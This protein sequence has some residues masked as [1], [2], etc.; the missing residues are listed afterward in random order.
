MKASY[1]WLR[2]LL[3]GLDLSPRDAG[4]RLTRA[5]L[6]LE[7]LIEYG[8]ASPHCVVATV[9]KKEP[10]PKR[11]RLTLVTVDRGDGEQTIVCGAPNVPE[12]G[13]KV[14]LAPVGVELPE[15]GFT[16]V[17]RDIA[18]VTSEGM[19]CSEGELGL[20][21][22]GKGDGILVLDKSVKA[23]AGTPF[24]KAVAGTHDWVLDIG[25]TP[26]RPDAL[27]HVGI[28]RELAALLE[29]DFEAP[30]ADAPARVAQGKTIDELA[31]VVID[32][33]ERCPHYG[34]AAVLDVK[35]GPSP[36]WLRYRLESLGIR[37]ISN[38]VDVTNLVLLEFAQPMH[39]FN[40]D[41]LPGGK[42]RV[43]R[44]KPGELLTTIDHVERKLV[45]DDLLIT[46]GERPIAL[47]GVMG[48][49]NSEIGEGASRVLLECAYFTSRGIRR[50]ARRHALHSEASHR[51][52]RGTDP[53]GVPMVLAHAASLLTNIA[54][55][56]AVS[57]TILAG[58]APAPNKVITL[59][60]PKMV[61]LLGLDIPMD[62]A[63]S[64]LERLGCE[65]LRSSETPDEV[66]VTA[67]SFRP[68]IGREEDV[69][70]E[71]MR[72]NGIDNVPTTPRAVLPKSGRSVPDV[73]SV[74]RRVAAEL[75]LSEALTYG[76]VAPWEL[77][78][79]A[80]PPPVV[81][82]KNPLTEERS[83]M[84]TS[85]LPGLLEALK[86]SRRHGVGDV[87][88]F[89]A[90]RTFL[91]A[92]EG[93]LPLESLRLAA[94]IAGERR[95]GLDKPQPLDVYDAKGLAV[96]LAERIGRAD[97][98]VRGLGK[99]APSHLHPR[100]AG[101]LLVAGESVGTFG[102]LH[103]DVIERFDLGGDALVVE[104]SL[105]VLDG[106]SREVPQ[107]RPVPVLPAVSRDLAV[108]VDE[109]VIA[110]DLEATIRSSAGELCESVEL[111]DRFA[112]KGV[113]DGQVS[114]AYHLIYRDP[115]AATAPDKART[116]TD[117]EV[118]ALYA[119]VVK[120]VAS[121]HGAT[122]RGA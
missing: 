26:N 67:P 10:H 91:A 96:E 82:L 22:G 56:S 107:Y 4:E 74:A 32:D 44:A 37:A 87:R 78:A 18:G 71:V 120:A 62:R 108:L 102:P 117:D 103:P 46:D 17:P 50:T 8:A 104:L 90:G 64:I 42:V 45:E 100:G 118:D 105:D 86:R 16:I 27:G 36:D 43:R 39:A 114:L 63:C 47:A 40:L 52:E 33:T 21:G 122:V 59:R 51:F 19:L 38:V 93:P 48:G 110:G 89:A 13:R 60:R 83:V 115:K 25:V 69:I 7:E 34:A 61:S 109:A 49:A 41:A 92:E 111:F 14:V 3:P 55:G 2:S 70:E 6:E 81:K 20:V 35:V 5:G 54:G 72:V 112:G 113:P 53:H 58:V 12:P 65:V 68:D 98:D 97:C 24:S 29:L 79:L 99:E 9:K 28:A 15:A 11:E 77:D 66:K 119:K 80:A 76:F 94:V 85:L 95:N 75:G 106:F 23:P 121:A 1:T 116:L 31:S 57:G 101:E 88:L 73:R 84:R 30:Q